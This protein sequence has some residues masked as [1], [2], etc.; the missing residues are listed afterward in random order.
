EEDRVIPGP[1]DSHHAEGTVAEPAARHQEPALPAGADPRFAQSPPPLADR[2]SNRVEAH[3][4]LGH[5]LVPGLADL[6]ADRVPRALAPAR[7]DPQP[8]LEDVATIFP[9]PSTPAPLRR[10]GPS[11]EG[12]DRAGRGGRDSPELGAVGRVARDQTIAAA[13]RDVAPHHAV[14]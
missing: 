5:R 4:H 9:G 12:G 14:T 11:H 3:D 6:G 1:N 2:P 10:S 8:A 7:Q 13:L